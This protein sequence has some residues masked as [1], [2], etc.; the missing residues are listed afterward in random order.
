MAQMQP[1]GMQGTMEYPKLGL[2]GHLLSPLKVAIYTVCSES[3]LKNIV[4][5][6][7]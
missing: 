1:R 6:G 4:L 2:L 5:I 7:K 3:S